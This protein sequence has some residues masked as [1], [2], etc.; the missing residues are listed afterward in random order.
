MEG[1]GVDAEGGVLF[2]KYKY[3]AKKTSLNS[4]WR[5]DVSVKAL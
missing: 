5:D 3:E 4:L 2:V 1:Y